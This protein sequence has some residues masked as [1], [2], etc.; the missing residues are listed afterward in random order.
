[1][2]TSLKFIVITCDI[3]IAY[4]LWLVSF[5]L[6]LEGAYAAGTAGF[7]FVVGI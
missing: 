4:I 5:S 3:H 2:L 1:M 6:Y 7:E